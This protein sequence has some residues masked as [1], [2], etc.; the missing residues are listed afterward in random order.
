MLPAAFPE[1][2]FYFQ[3]ADMVTQ[4]LNFGIP[5]QIDVRTVGYDRAKNL[6]I[7]HEL[8]RRIAEIPGIADAHL[9]QE[10]DAP[11]FFV[12]I[13]RSRAAQF[14]LTAN[15]IVTNLNV[16]LSSS[17]QVSHNFWTDQST[18]IPYYIAFRHRSTA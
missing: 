6:R 14:G 11:D 13:D 12:D 4:I 15:Q 18:G 16:S 7:A 17:E 3:A 9:Q 1:E 10:V 8:R 2:I 5:A